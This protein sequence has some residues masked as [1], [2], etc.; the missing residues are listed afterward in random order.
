MLQKTTTGMVVTRYWVALLFQRYLSNTASLVLWG[1]RRVK[2]R[3]N[4]LHYSPRRDTAPYHSTHRSWCRYAG[5]RPSSCLHV[6]ASMRLSVS[7]PRSV[8]VCLCL[9]LLVS[10]CRCWSMSVPVCL[11]LSVA[12]C[13]ALSLSVS[14]TASATASAPLRLRLLLW[15]AIIN[16]N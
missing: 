8:A 16:S 3:H 13:L 11:R 5:L 4:L 6:S 10:V 12:V 7:A 2:D 14:A 15:I 1:V 9:S